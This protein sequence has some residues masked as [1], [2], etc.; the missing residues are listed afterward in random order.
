MDNRLRTFVSTFV[1][2]VFPVIAV[3][4][5]LTGRVIASDGT[6]VTDASVS[7]VEL[8][9]DVSTGDDGRFTFTDVAPGEYLL[10]VSSLRFGAAVVRV[11]VD[12]DARPVEIELD[13]RIHAGTIS[14]TATG[15]AR[16]LDEI[17]A[18]VDV[19]ADEQL[20]LRREP[21]LGDTLANQPGVAATGYGRGS[22]RPVIR[23]LDA[24][25]IG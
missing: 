3:A 8:R 4:T 16:G 22:S 18:P 20:A 15:R 21:T 9:R 14:V 10:E 19:L 6:P 12:D 1:A 23:G 25:R 17:A 13:Q 24:D 2:A 5:D 11:A 7:L